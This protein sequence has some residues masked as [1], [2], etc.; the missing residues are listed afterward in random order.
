MN[1]VVYYPHI[2]PTDEWLKLAAL[3][4]DKVYR[5][6]P[7]HWY[8]PPIIEELDT[9]LGGILVN[10]GIKQVA[11]LEVQKQFEEWIDARIDKL[12]TGELHIESQGLSHLIEAS[13]TFLNVL[14][15]ESTPKTKEHKAVEDSLITTLHGGKM[16]VNGFLDLLEKHGLAWTEERSI[17]AQIPDWEKHE[18]DQKKYCESAIL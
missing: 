12:K 7:S 10:V 8:D 3:C 14:P 18:Y 1:T 6:V 13:P 16:V 15:T 4:W 17:K 9:A 2:Y 5:L 11:D